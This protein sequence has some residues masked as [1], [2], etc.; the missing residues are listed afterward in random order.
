MLLERIYDED[1]AQAS[2][3]IGCQAKGEAIVV[4]AR[5]DIRVYQDL[6]AKNDM[7][8]TAV[9]ETHIH[10]DYLSGTRE[11]A[12]AT[13]ATIHVSGEGGTD[14][15]YEFDAERLFDQDT[16]TLGNISIKALHTPGHTP[17]HLSFL[18]TDGAFSHE[19]GFLLSGDFVFSGDLGRPDLLDEAAGGTDTR[20]AGAHDLFVSLRE[21]FLALPDYVQVYPGHGAGSACGKAL[22][23]IPS[24]TVGYERNFA[25]WG[26]YLAANDETGF[27]AEL[28]DGQPDAHA[29]F[30]RMKR[31][32]RQ[33]PVVMGKRAPLAE[34]AAED[35]AAAL[36][37]DE[38]GV[39]DTR[40][41]SLVHE[42]TVAGALNIPAGN[43]AA[44]YGAWAVD[45]QTDKRPLVLLAPGVETAT[46]MW[47]HL[48]RVGI[49]NVAGYITSLDGLPVH[50]PETLAPADLAG[51][52]A[53]MLLDVRNKTEH[54]A[55]HI[56]G[57]KQLN[58]GRVLWH[59]DQ[60]PADG[61]IVSYCQSGVRNSVAASALRRAGHNVVELTG[62]YAGWNAWKQT[63]DA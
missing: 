49:D 63:Q 53:A 7:K 4:D 16:I 45:P 3:F 28:L 32:N 39:V 34:L 46:E 44:S 27:V 50:T 14:W 21:K 52:D 43:K 48:I 29:Y 58:A 6:A 36:V 40:H 11:L 41:H 37:A 42:G 56:P 24:S 35:V 62:S 33:G 30:G 1:L 18:I 54:T 17:E 26:P 55:G 25:W 9:T 13:D 61:A 23:A 51:F 20:F 19:P 5:R 60:L 2:Y 59:T 57:S 22:G 8:I 38:I 47:D 15:Q 10:A 12:A 31:E